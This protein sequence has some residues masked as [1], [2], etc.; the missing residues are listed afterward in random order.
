MLKEG[1]PSSFVIRHSSF[2]GTL[3]FPDE[4]AT[5]PPMPSF[6][7]VSEVDKMEIETR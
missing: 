1:P 2:V 5:I 3:A 7:I 6:D 4:L